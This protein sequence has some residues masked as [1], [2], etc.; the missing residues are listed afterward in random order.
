MLNFIKGK[1]AKVFLLYL[2]FFTIIWSLDLPNIFYSGNYKQN[3]SQNLKKNLEAELK[4]LADSSE[5][6]ADDQWV[7]RK[8]IENDEDTLIA[9][10]SEQRDQ[11]QIPY[12]LAVDEDGL[13]IA[14]LKMSARDHDYP[15]FL[16]RWGELVTN[17][18]KISTID[19]TAYL[20]LALLSA[21]PFFKDEQLAGAIVTAFLPDDDY[22]LAFKNKYLG[23]KDHIAFFSNAS[24]L[25]GDSFA[26][27]VDLKIIEPMLET[28]SSWISPKKY[29][30]PERLHLGHQ[31][32]QLIRIDLPLENDLPSGGVFLLIHQNNL[33]YYL[34][35]S[36]ILTIIFYLLLHYFGQSLSVRKRIFYHLL[37]VL[38][39]LLSMAWHFFYSSRQ[40]FSPRSIDF[41]IFNASL[42]INPTVSNWDLNS[43]QTF[44]VNLSS[45]GEKIR[46]AKVELSYDK[47]AIKINRISNDASVCQKNAFLDKRVD[48]EAGL[49]LVNCLLSDQSGAIINNQPIFQVEVTPLQEKS[50]EVKFSP[51]SQIIS[52]DS[53]PNNTTVSAHGAYF[54]IIRSESL[55]NNNIHI[56]SRSHPNPNKWYS[57]QIIHI[58]WSGNSDDV[59]SYSLD[60]D[61][62]T[63]A[64]G[65][66]LTLTKT[67]TLKVAGDGQ[68]Y[69]H[70]AK[71]IG[72]SW[73]PTTHQSFQIDSQAPDIKKFY[74]NK[75]KPSVN[76]VPQ[77]YF[78]AT[79]NMN[80]PLS[81][82]L[83]L[84]KQPFT[85]VTSPTYIAPLNDH[86]HHA[87]LRV[88]DNAGNYSERSINFYVSGNH[89]GNLWEF[90][91]KLFD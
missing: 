65:A 64:Q 32:Y 56:F 2:I 85:L 50:F 40:V 69:F 22:T 72:E 81:Y 1:I 33:G 68:Y 41:K 7:Q 13:S 75:E 89:L 8:I 43:E 30:Y 57:S 10:F 51:T 39:A 23:A 59:F 9:K 11:Y 25:I 18:Q 90:I 19:Y 66:N 87:I 58:A 82:Y 29:Y 73:G 70:I 20:P 46:A 4:I 86:S 80:T 83:S 35:I 60:Q 54:N 45:G 14:R 31:D 52:E 63:E 34:I 62:T 38:L 26:D 36:L 48:A 12:I 61:P 76:D 53:N 44:S 3:I 16:T 78:E 42:K 15:L 37:L 17:Q 74:I 77:L 71:K 79:D 55:K 24:G 47:N 5:R 6:L 28:G 49:I 21:T 84:D 67:A 91:K 27:N 88:V